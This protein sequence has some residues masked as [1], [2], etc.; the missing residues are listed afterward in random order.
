MSAP[1]RVLKAM[2]PPA[3]RAPRMA[4]SIGRWAAG[5]MLAVRVRQA[6]RLSESQRGAPAPEAA[7]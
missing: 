6:T 4:D 7:P 1:A 2:V 5:V 3:I